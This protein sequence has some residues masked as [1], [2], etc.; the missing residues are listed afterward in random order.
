M[1]PEGRFLASLGQSRMMARAWAL[2]RICGADPKTMKIVRSFLP[3]CCAVSFALLSCSAS[4]SSVLDETRVYLDEYN[5][6]MAYLTIEKAYERNPSDKDIEATF[7]KVRKLFLLKHG[8]HQVFQQRELEGLAVLEKVLTLDADNSIALEWIEKAKLKLA[9]RAVNTGEEH[10]VAGRLKEALKSYQA[11]LEYVP[12][13]SDAIKGKK[14]LADVWGSRQ[15]KAQ[16]SYTEGLRALSDH[17][18]RQTGYHM[19]IALEKDPGLAKAEPPRDLAHLRRAEERFLQ[20][21]EWVDE[22]YFA[23]ALAEFKLLLGKMPGR[24]D[25][26]KALMADMQQEVKA[27]ELQEKGEMAVFRGEFAEARELLLEAFELSESN[28][29]EISDSLLFVSER[30]LEYRYLVAKDSEFQGDLEKALG[31]YVA[32]EED[33]IPGMEATK[34]GDLKARIGGLQSTIVEAQKS[35][36]AGEAAEARNDIEAAIESYQE[37][38]DVFP[39]YR[40]LKVRIE[41]L[42]AAKSTGE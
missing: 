31:L 12:G 11:A 4:S 21:R 17:K 36:D 28:R 26:L 42:E 27:R 19:G 29:S 18:Y 2:L 39:G 7:W 3:V 15:E 40:N 38:L 20:A 24:D 13:F 10:Q 1:E 37:A 34:L 25:E 33:M 5:I 14:Q 8:Q 41:K 35:F 16:G 6:G 32:I 23:P 9:K 22:G 30:E